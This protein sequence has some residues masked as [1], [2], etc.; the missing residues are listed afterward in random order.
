MKKINDAVFKYAVDPVIKITGIALLLD[1]ML[2]IFGRAFMAKP[3]AWTEELSRFLFLWYCFLGCAVT[4]C[5]KQHLGLDFF[6][7]KFSA[8]VRRVID[9]CI[10]VLTLV[11]GGYLA[12]YGFQVLTV[13][14][15]RT[16]PITGW[17]MKWF[18]LVLPIMGILF[19]MLAVENIVEM[20][21]NKPDSKKEENIA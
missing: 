19:V 12:F 4:L 8:K 2:Q 1:I 16:A 3:P 21:K 20:I 9:Y 11:F 6:Y 13:V 18:Y 14:T 10:H 7:N 15:K 5:N 17:S